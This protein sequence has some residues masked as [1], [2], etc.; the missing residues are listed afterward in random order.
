MIWVH[1]Y[2]WDESKREWRPLLVAPA[3]DAEL[4]WLLQG[5]RWFRYALVPEAE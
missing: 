5:D 4:W 3:V 2:G 1:L